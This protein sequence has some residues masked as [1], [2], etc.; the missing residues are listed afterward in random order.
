VVGDRVGGDP[1]HPGAHAVGVLEVR[2]VAVDAQ[3][4]VLRDVLGV[5]AAAHPSRDEREDAV[6]QLAARDLR[7]G[8]GSGRCHRTRIVASPAR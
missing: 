1:A 5:L 2:A 4:H 8:A 7:R 3:H 6:L